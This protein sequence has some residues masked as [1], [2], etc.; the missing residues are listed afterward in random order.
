MSPFKEIC[1]FSAPGSVDYIKFACDR[2]LKLYKVILY[3]LRLL[4]LEDKKE[5][6]CHYVF[7][8]AQDSV[9]HPPVF[10]SVIKL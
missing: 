2:D 10:N 6:L 3:D 8:W 5:N 4:N 7:C 1:Q 9:G